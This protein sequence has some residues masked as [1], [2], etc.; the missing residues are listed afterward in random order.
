VALRIPAAPPAARRIEHRVAGA[1]ANPYLVLA[2]V[3]AGLHYGLTT[4]A[5]PGRPVEGNA[6]EQVP[7]SLPITWNDAISSLEAAR[8]LPD[9]LGAD[10]CRLY[11][12]C[13]AAERDRFNDVIT[14]TERL[15]P[16]HRLIQA[17]TGCAAGFCHPDSRL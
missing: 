10:F 5:D 9:Y 8:I 16:A 15:V 2:A 17:S 3:L 11:G 4:E 14:P 1:D 13:R 7:P 6:Y 12:T